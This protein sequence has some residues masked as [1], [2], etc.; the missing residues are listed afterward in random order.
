MSAKVGRVGKRLWPEV[1]ISSLDK[2]IEE[3]VGAAQ[4]VASPAFTH[5]ESPGKLPRTC[6]VRAIK[7]RIIRAAAWA[8]PNLFFDLSDNER[9]GVEIAQ[10]S[11]REDLDS[12]FVFRKQ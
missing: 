11:F 5:N 12:S 9:M 6:L 8:V 2:P 7:E 4:A 3:T 1:L 10:F